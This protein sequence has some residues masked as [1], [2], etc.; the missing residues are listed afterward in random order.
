MLFFLRK[1]AAETYLSQRQA[2]EA[3]AKVEACSEKVSTITR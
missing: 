1:S 3:L 2:K